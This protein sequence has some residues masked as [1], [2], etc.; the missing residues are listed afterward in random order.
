M[1]TDCLEIVNLWNTRINSHSVV[2]PVFFEI[3]ELAVFDSFVISHVSRSANGPTHLWAQ[4]TCNASVTESWIS[5]T[6]SFLVSSLMA[7]F[8]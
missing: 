5:E 3:E 7:T 1:E 8:I 2:A 4:R 6:P